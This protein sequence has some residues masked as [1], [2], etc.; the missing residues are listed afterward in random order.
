MRK[1]ENIAGRIDVVALMR[2]WR[3]SKDKSHWETPSITRTRLD[4]VH[5]E[6]QL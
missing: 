4:T 1:A 5:V 3:R 2:R 6:Q